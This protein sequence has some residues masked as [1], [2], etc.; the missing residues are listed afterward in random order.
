MTKYKAPAL[1]KGLDIIDLIRL[2]GPLSFK[3]LQDHTG[4]NPASL[5]RYLHTLMVKD[6]IHKSGSQKYTLGLKLKDLT[7]QQSL[8]PLLSQHLAPFMANLSHKYQVTLLLIAYTNDQYTV[9]EKAIAQDNLGM[10]PKGTIGENDPT[11]LWSNHLYSYTH[12]IDDYLKTLD[13]S[14]ANFDLK[15]VLMD[16][17]ELDYVQLTTETKQIIRLGFPIRFNNRVIATLAIGSFIPQLPDDIKKA[18]IVQVRTMIAKIEPL[19]N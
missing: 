7:N 5:S 14:K 8:W 17:K 12:T 4:D 9:I 15:A 1:A 19:L 6:Y 10:M 13:L 18:I 3:E 2:Y 16:L 11:N